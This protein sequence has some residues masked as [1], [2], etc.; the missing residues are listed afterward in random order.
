MKST[1]TPI[2]DP[3]E[4]GA[5]IAAHRLQHLLWAGYGTACGE[6]QYYFESTRRSKTID[7]MAE[8]IV[9]SLKHALMEEIFPARPTH[10]DKLAELQ[11]RL[12]DLEGRYDILAGSYFRTQEHTAAMIEHLLTLLKGVLAL[13]DQSTGTKDETTGPAN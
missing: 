3:V 5:Y 2:L 4:R 8:I 1:Y 10:D 9:E 7:T 12:I 13:A 6:R 11:E